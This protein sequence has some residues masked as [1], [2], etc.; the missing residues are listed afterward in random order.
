[1]IIILVSYYAT[2]SIYLTILEFFF[3]FDFFTRQ[4]KENDFDDVCYKEHVWFTYLANLTSVFF[5][6]FY[7][8]DEWNVGKKLIRRLC[9]TRARSQISTEKRLKRVMLNAKLSKVTSGCFILYDCTSSL[10]WKLGSG[11]WLLSWELKFLIS[12]CLML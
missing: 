11:R 7:L 9:S 5:V 10:I 1:M 3:G 6:T 12:V 8:A 2:V 4:I